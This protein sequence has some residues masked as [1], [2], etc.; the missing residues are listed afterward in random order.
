MWHSEPMM[1]I[2]LLRWGM[3]TYAKHVCRR[4]RDRGKRSAEREI[5]E[6]S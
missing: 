4:R 3:D 2:S 6:Y 1:L 5:T